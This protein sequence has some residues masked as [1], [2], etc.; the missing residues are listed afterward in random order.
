MTIISGQ[1]I[2]ERKIID[3]NYFEERQKVVDPYG[4]TTT[5]GLGPAGYDLSLDEI[6]VTKGIVLADLDSLTWIIQPGAFA[7]AS[8]REPINMPADLIGTVHDKSSW[9]RRGLTV[10]NTVVEPGWRGYLT[11]ELKNIGNEMLFLTHGSGIC[12]LLFHS[13]DAPAERPYEGKYQDQSQG[14]QEA[15]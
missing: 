3:P 10:Q 5:L 14:P 8:A 15:L 6:D 7:L 11:L 13:L 12:Q 2:R 4:M 9:A 1:T